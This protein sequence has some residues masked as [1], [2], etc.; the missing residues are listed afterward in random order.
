[1]RL[2]RSLA[3]CS[4]LALAAPVL[5]APSAAPADVAAIQDVVR[6]FQS[7]I[8]AKDGKAL[9]NLFLADHN[10]WLVVMDDA[11]YA[12]AKARNANVAKVKTSTWKAFAD[13]V[14]NSKVPVEERFHNV[15][16]E[17]NGAVASVYFDF[18]FLID[19]KVTNRGS[20]AWQMVRDE[21]GWKIGAMLFSVGR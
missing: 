4:A 12:A 21:Q 11:E 16:I 18:D 8:V 13:F 14:A 19:G 15:R 5:A 17:T 6:Q 7:A 1:M 9:G 3:F 2:I 10:S 20:E